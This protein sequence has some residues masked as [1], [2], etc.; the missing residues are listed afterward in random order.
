MSSHGLPTLTFDLHSLRAQR[1]VATGAVSLAAVAC[2][3]F[4]GTIGWSLNI[5]VCFMTGSVIAAAFHRAGWL[6]RR[7]CLT[8]ITWR[9][10]GC[11]IVTDA[12][13]HNFEAALRPDS[14][15]SPHIIWLCWLIQDSHDVR[16]QWNPW[17]RLQSSLLLVRGDVPQGDFRRLLV[18]LRVDRSECAPIASQASSQL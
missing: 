16:R 7:H 12:R 4:R 5:L 1:Y 11:W 10:D 8:R 18:R 6:G 17:R 2:V 3:L 14:R 13:G 15:M 9:S